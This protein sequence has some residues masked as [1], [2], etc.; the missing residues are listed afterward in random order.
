MNLLTK[1]V[2]AVIPAVSII[3]IANESPA[4]AVPPP[5]SDDTSRILDLDVD[6]G[7]YTLLDVVTIEIEFL[8]Q[9]N[10][11]I[12]FWPVVA[13]RN[14]LDRE[15]HSSGS[16]RP[17]R[18]FRLAPNESV[19]AVF[20]WGIPDSLADGTY[21]VVA[22]LR[23][24]DDISAS[25][26]TVEFEEEVTFRVTARPVIQVSRVAHD[27]GTFR[28]GE[29]PTSSF[30]VD[31]AGG[32]SL[33]WR[34]A[35]WP[36]W[37]EL[38]SPIVNSMS[39]NLQIRVSD[40]IPLGTHEASIFVESEVGRRR[41]VLTAEVVGEI[42]GRIV[43]LT[44]GEDSYAQ[45]DNASIVMKVENNGDVPI[46][47]EAV[48]T[49]EDSNGSV[50][51]NNSLDDAPARVF[52]EPFSPRDVTFLW[53]VP[54]SSYLGNYNVSAELR[55]WNDKAHVF[56]SVSGSNRL[57]FEVTKGPTI[58]VSPD[59]WAFIV[60]PGESAETS[61]AVSGVSNFS[62]RWRVESWPEWLEVLS[63]TST[64]N[65][66]GSVETR[67]KGS[68]A[69]GAYEGELLISSNEGNKTI[70]LL[71]IVQPPPPT[72][73]RTPTIT[74]TPTTTPGA[75][76]PDDTPTATVTPTPTIETPTSTATAEPTRTPAA[77]ATGLP[78]TATSTPAVQP[79]ST[80]TPTPRLSPT[81][82]RSNST[83]VTRLPTRTSTPTQVIVDTGL[84]TPPPPVGGCRAVFGQ[85][86]S[87][88]AGNI[89]VLMAPFA[90]VA[91]V[92]LKRLRGK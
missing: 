48:I 41:I 82:R 88:G 58:T 68:N 75:M 84:V 70:P 21:T 72:P 59:S 52:L 78:P 12:D 50:I 11:T 28:Y 89:V 62:F 40:K 53:T 45:S 71:L 85:S 63:S 1:L 27:F 61:L 66:R 2:I 35:E 60:N 57:T 80:P 54:P 10:V 87:A 25:Y 43:E 18:R 29:S 83:P 67:V 86:A 33:E 8:N 32:S 4:L 49:I 24:W 91:I 36:E 47:Y 19:T 76:P 23:D 22:N 30:R 55:D 15:I 44:S 64:I 20:K 3:L 90:L 38:L 51:Y 13:V 39:G 69:P 73:T 46:D 92:K 14:S 26:D 17:R 79:T 16:E 77:T 37:I 31:T 42:H 7:S 56:D 6:K 5:Q 65:G 9:S 74:P 34:V 81:A